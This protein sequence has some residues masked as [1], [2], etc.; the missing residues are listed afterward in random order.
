MKDKAIV[1]VTVD[2]DAVSLWMNWGATGE[3]TLARGE[4]GGR[5]GA[6][7]LLDVFAR[8]GIATTWFIPGHTVDTYPDFVRS[9]HEAGHEIGNHGYCH[10]S[11]NQISP[12][13]VARVVAA[14]SNSIERVTGKRPLGMR[15]P[16]GDFDGSLFE[17]LE[18]E[19]FVYNSSVVGEYDAWHCHAKGELNFDRPNT[20]GARLQLVQ[21]PLSFV[22]NDFN[23][24]EF[25]YGDPQLHGLCSPDYV[26]GIWKAQFDYMYANVPGG[27]LNLTLHPQS[28]GWGLRAAMLERFIRYCQEKP[29]CVFRTCLDVANE[30]KALH[31]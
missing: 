7:R 17:F 2:F 15:V 4:F 9:V 16:A 22:M 26:E 12:D 20:P 1:C 23:Y 30:F 25:N 5:I 3:R 11:F 29:G 14:G 19:G 13:D 24:Y 6:P 21:L 27:I 10:E 18:R 8:T 28:S 31:P